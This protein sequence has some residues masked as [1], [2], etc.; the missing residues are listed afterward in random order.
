MGQYYHPISLTSFEWLY[1]NDYSEGLKIM[2][3]SWVG[4]KFIG[5]I[6]K[7]LTK[8][9]KWYK[10]KIVWA[11]DYSE[12]VLNNNNL[13]SMCYGFSMGYGKYDDTNI[14]LFEIIN[15]KF[16][17]NEQEQKKA[18]IVNHAK[19]EYVKI[20]DCKKDG[21][22][23]IINPLPLLTALGNGGGG[24]DYHGSNMNLIGRWASDEISVEFDEKELEG[25]SKIIPNFKEG[26]EEGNSENNELMAYKEIK[27]W[28][29]SK[30]VRDRI[31]VEA[32]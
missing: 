28:C 20:S 32:I 27:R 30:E 12:E 18:I 23:W 6:M 9:N 22:G 24:G 15:L 16:L 4:S 3:H 25:F 14:R 26:E 5:V 10:N 1:P 29:K 7:L 11:G 2:E 19:K 17:L 13:Y 31:I 21:E 8:G